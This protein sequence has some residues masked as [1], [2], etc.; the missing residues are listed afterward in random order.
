MSTL[1]GN[2]KESGKARSEPTILNP[3][4]ILEVD[5]DTVV[6]AFDPNEKPVKAEP[7]H[8][9]KY[10]VTKD[11]I[12]KDQGKKIVVL[13]LVDRPNLVVSVVVLHKLPHEF[14]RLLP[15]RSS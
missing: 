2:N 11:F 13:R 7:L 12:E 3:T 15:F 1:N 10:P 14:W 6:Y 8:K 4:H 9:G 5:T